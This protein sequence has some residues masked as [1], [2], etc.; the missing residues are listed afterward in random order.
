MYKIIRQTVKSESEYNR[1]SVKI[2]YFP[3]DLPFIY[4]LYWGI[5]KLQGGRNVWKQQKLYHQLKN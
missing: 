1:D 4:N 2:E 5:L 3:L